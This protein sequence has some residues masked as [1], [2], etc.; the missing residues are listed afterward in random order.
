[1]SKPMLT[2][3]IAVTI[4][5]FMF[6]V[7]AK[8]D[9]EVDDYIQCLDNKNAYLEARIDYCVNILIQALLSNRLPTPCYPTTVAMA[10]IKQIRQDC[11]LKP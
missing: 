6:S 9:R 5:C 8:A 10:E 11:K 2:S 4:F 1:M 3:L 7:T